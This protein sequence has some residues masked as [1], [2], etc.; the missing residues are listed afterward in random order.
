MVENIL[1]DRSDIGEYGAPSR[2]APRANCPSCPPLSAALLP[3]IILIYLVVLFYFE[4]VFAWDIIVFVKFMNF[5]RSTIIDYVIVATLAEVDQK[6]ARLLSSINCTI[7]T[8]FV[9]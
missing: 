2:V 7:F 8:E 4:G 5:Y 1:H 3:G 9:I 6:I